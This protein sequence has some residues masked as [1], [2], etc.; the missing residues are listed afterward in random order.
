MIAVTETGSPLAARAAYMRR[1]PLVLVNGL[2]EQAETWFANTPVWRQHFDVHTPA[3]APYDGPVLHERIDRGEPIDVDFLVERLH[4]YVS[5]FV[6]TP[7]DLLANSMGGK[8]AVEFTVRHPAW[9]RRLV[10]LSPAGLAVEERLPMVTGAKRSDIETLVGSVFHATGGAEPGLVAYYAARFRDRRWKTG[11]LRTIRGTMTHS[12]R[13]RLADVPQPTLLVVGLEDRIVDPRSSI[14]AG[15]R[16][17]HG[18]IVTLA[19]CGHA[20]QI[21]QAGVVN[22]LVIQYLAAADPLRLEEPS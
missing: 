18:R 11:L 21:E 7:V 6:Q 8:I 15:Q 19:E 3:L 14:F 12:V 4:A 5:G 16:L 1:S 10:L 2:A 9:V 17:P 13:D 22:E 20:P